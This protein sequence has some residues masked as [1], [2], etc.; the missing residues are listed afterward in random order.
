MP[1]VADPAKG[2]ST[3][4]DHVAV[5]L[6]QRELEL[7][8]AK[9]ELI[10]QNGI[11]FYRPHEKQHEFHKSAAKRRGFF[12]GNRTGKSECS[13]AETA[14]W[15]L[16]ERTW[17]KYT[18]PIYGMRQGKRVIIEMHEGH[19]N[20]PLVRQGIPR[21]ATKQLIITTDWKKVDIVWTSTFGDPP[22]KIWKFLPKDIDI[23]TKKNHEGTIDQIFNRRTGA[24]IRFTTEQ[25]FMKNPQSAESTDNDRIAIDEPIIEDMWKASARGLLDRDGQGDFTLTSLR[26][27]WIYDYFNPEDTVD[28]REDRFSIRAT[29]YDNPYNSTEALSRFE[30]E[31]TEDERECRLM[32]LPLELSGLV[33]KQFARETHVL[34]ELPTNWTAWNNP[35]ADWTIYVGVDVH[36]QTPQAAMFIAVPPV[37]APIIYDEIWRKCVIDELVEEIKRRIDGRILGFIKADPAAWREDPVFKVSAASRFFNSG[38][39]IEQASKAKSFGIQNMQSVLAKRIETAG[40]K[41][42]PAVFFAPTVKQTLWEISRYHFDKENKPVDK[43]DH[44][45]ENMYRLFIT[46]LPYLDVSPLPPLAQFDIPM[47]RRALHDFDVDR[48]RYSLADGFRN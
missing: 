15:F 21:H 34:K 36:E 27:R 18:F 43:D 2:D 6:K 25:A 16:G 42:R 47:T 46:P 12:A 13:A 23:D 35:P 14:A 45:M 5:A 7:L 39:Y 10:K 28:A 3:E 48:S 32:G 9:L 31:L 4:P 40:G 38:L 22:G 44:F 37:G 26:E 30:A 41:P 8:R 19:E 24:V 1:P 29:T 20:H 11:A 17:Y 33:Y